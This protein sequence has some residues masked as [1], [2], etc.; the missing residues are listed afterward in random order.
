MH[1]SGRDKMHM[2]C[3]LAI[4]AL[5]IYQGVFTVDLLALHAHGPDKLPPLPFVVN[6]N[7]K[8]HKQPMWQSSDKSTALSSKSFMHT[9][10]IIVKA[11]G[12][13]CK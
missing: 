11:L 10:K 8:W 1:N 13:L 9:G 3:L 6:V 12:W 7:E 2:D 4:K 5:G